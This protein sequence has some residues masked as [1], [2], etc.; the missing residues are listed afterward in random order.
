MAAAVVSYNQGNPIASQLIRNFLHSQ[1]KLCYGA[2]SRPEVRMRLDRRRR[3][4]VTA[5]ER[6]FGETIAP[7]PLDPSVVQPK[8]EGANFFI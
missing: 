2:Q 8:G 5:T 7:A 3:F 1:P 6:K 4:G